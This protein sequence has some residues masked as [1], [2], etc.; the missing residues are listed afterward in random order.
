[1]FTDEADKYYLFADE[2]IVLRN[3]MS[4]PTGTLVS[5]TTRQA[6]VIR[7]LLD[8]LDYYHNEGFR[9]VVDVWF[10]DDL[11]PHSCLEQTLEALCD[12]VEEVLPNHVYLGNHPGD[13]ADF[14]I[15]GV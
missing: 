2:Y 14:G 13:G 8:W 12:A 7:A 4:C 11:Q 10:D 3:G 9:S 1:M 15:W 5:G 6:P